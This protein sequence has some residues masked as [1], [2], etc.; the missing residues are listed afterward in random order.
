MTVAKK[1]KRAWYAGLTLAQRAIAN[2]IG[3]DHIRAFYDERA[4]GVFG[5]PGSIWSIGDDGLAT[6]RGPKPADIARALPH[7]FK[8]RRN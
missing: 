1:R 6:T 7:D 8:L 5:A 2:E 4:R 3:N